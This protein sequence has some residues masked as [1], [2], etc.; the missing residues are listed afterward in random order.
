MMLYHSI[1]HRIVDLEGRKT[2]NKTIILQ[3][4]FK[5][6]RSALQFLSQFGG[7]VLIGLVPFG[8]Q[9]NDILLNI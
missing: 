5:C 4:P 9:K 1:V 2:I 7:T 3:C 6:H 8:A